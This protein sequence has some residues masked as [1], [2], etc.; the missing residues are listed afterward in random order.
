M[1]AI[2]IWVKGSTAGVTK[3]NPVVAGTVGLPVAFSYDETWDDLSK[4]VVFRVNGKTM[5]CVN[6]N[7]STVVPWELLQKSGCRLLCGVYGCNTEGTLQIPTV[8]VDLGVIE[9]GANPS[10]DESAEPSLPVWE[11]VT[12][13]IEEA[14]DHIIALERGIIDGHTPLG[15]KEG[16]PV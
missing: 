16:E 11:Q 12:Q 6:C 13:G 8:W 5:D 9:P 3:G 14:L 15:T 10:G 7:D 4:T 2:Q 1:E